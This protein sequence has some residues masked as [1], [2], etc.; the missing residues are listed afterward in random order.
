MGDAEPSASN[1]LLVMGAFLV[2]TC[3]VLV[4]ARVVTFDCVVFASLEV[5]FSEAGVSELDMPT[6][7][8]SFL[9]RSARAR[10][11]MMSSIGA[12]QFFS[13][14]FV[15]VVQRTFSARAAMA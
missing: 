11:Q 15:E 6:S 12:F 4:F 7:G 5:R 3:L 1:A 14:F 13:G 8:E 2:K 9:S 10:R